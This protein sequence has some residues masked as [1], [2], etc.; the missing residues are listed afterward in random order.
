MNRRTFFSQ[1]FTTGLLLKLTRWPD[2]A[3]GAG[4]SDADLSGLLTE[5]LFRDPIW[6]YAVPNHPLTATFSED[7]QTLLLNER[8]MSNTNRVRLVRDGAGRV[9][10]E[11]DQVDSQRD[12]MSESTLTVE[13]LDP[14]LGELYVLSFKD[15]VA[16]R[17]RY[18]LAEQDPSN[19]SPSRED[20]VCGW[21]YENMQVTSLGTM[22]LEGVEC[23]G[24]IITAS[25]HTETMMNPPFQ[26]SVEDWIA[27][28]LCTPLLTKMSINTG[29]STER[30]RRLSNIIEGEP[31]LELLRIPSGFRI[32]EFKERTEEVREMTWEEFNA[33]FDSRN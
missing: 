17:Y 14:L 10:F 28:R 26:V 27:P 8:R 2:K 20:I 4:L 5:R 23:Y 9:R 15:K 7:Q 31:D 3:D 30:V 24:Q 6:S 22:M 1:L 32:E 11:E 16:T 19:T 13:I 21:R 29:L 33:Q 18:G 12:E 25:A